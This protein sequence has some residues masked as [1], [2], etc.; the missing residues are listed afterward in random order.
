[1]S[2]THNKPTQTGNY[3]IQHYNPTTGLPDCITEIVL[4]AFDY[5]YRRKKVTRVIAKFWQCNLED[6]INAKWSE[7]IVPPD[8]N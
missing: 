3:W 2:M 5:S 7:M 6:V 1:M 4:V 8:F